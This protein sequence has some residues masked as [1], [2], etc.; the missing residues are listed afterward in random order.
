MYY[1]CQHI[2]ARLSKFMKDD[3]R[4]MM[5]MNFSHFSQEAQGEEMGFYNSSTI[6]LD[7]SVKELHEQ[8]EELL[9][10]ES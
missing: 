8:R 2:P 6:E 4:T 10:G 3:Y 9:I 7:V 5:R 1:W